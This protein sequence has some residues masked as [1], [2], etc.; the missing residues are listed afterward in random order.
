MENVYNAVKNSKE[1][2]IIVIVDGDDWLIS[3]HVLS[4]LYNVGMLIIRD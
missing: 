3:E 1:G 4:L 2:T